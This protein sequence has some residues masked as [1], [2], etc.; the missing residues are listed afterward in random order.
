[1]ILL[2]EDNA[3]NQQVIRRQFNTLGFQCGIAND[4]VEAF[5]MWQAKDYR[6]LLIDCH[7]PEW[8]DFELTDAVHK[9]EKD[10]DKRSPIIAITANALQGEAERCFAAGMD[11]Y[12]SKPV[13]VTLLKQTLDK[14][15]DSKGGEGAKPARA[16]AALNLEKP[17]SNKAASDRSPSPINER[18]LKDMVGEGEDIFKE[19]LLSFIEPS[20]EIIKALQAA[21]EAGSPADVKAQAHK[22]KSSS[23]SAGAD[24]LVDVCEQMKDAGGANDWPTVEV[25]IPRV[26]PLYASVEANIRAV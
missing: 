22:L 17:P 24:E 23:R 5:E 18:M 19:V 11:D 7:M 16:S 1:M 13:D 6:I 26:D 21:F 3:T 15:I 8:D 4:G 14:W 20:E 9:L 25:L 10:S 2:A 12:L